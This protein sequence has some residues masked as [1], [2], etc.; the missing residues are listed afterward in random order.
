MIGGGIA[1]HAMLGIEAR[2][3]AQSSRVS[4]LAPRR[5]PL[6]AQGPRL[7][8]PKKRGGMIHRLIERVRGWPNLLCLL[9][10]HPYKTP[11]GIPDYRPDELSDT[12]CS[13]C[14][15]KLTLWERI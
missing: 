10:G 3:A 14:G 12:C 8:L 15:K 7:K 4:V 2:F 9:F 5:R 13:R 6:P 11:G 1:G